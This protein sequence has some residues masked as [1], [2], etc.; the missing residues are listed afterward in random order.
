[1]PLLDFTHTY[2]HVQSQFRF[3][4]ECYLNL[5]D[6]HKRVSEVAIA[7]VADVAVVAADPSP[8]SV[9]VVAS[10]QSMPEFNMRTVRMIHLYY[11]IICCCHHALAVCMLCFYFIIQEMHQDQIVLSILNY[12]FCRCCDNFSLCLIK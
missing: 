11:F 2:V 3:D 1:M 12:S 9:A 7:G 6:N 10:T 8:A 4:N 5:P